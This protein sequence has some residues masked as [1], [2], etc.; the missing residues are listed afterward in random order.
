MVK[1]NMSQSDAG[2]PSIPKVTPDQEAWVK[3]RLCTLAR[4]VDVVSRERLVGADGPIVNGAISG[5]ING[6]AVE[7]VRAL[8]LENIFGNLEQPVRL[9]PAEKREVIRGDAS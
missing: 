6:C 4:I 2:T 5:A 9:H 1:D 3:D 7:V 8:G